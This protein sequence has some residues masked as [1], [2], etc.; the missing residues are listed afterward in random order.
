MPAG[1]LPAGPVS[2]EAGE[3]VR[4]LACSLGLLLVA[5]SF[6]QQGERDGL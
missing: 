5:Q 4:P 6:L 1:L 2:L 3:A